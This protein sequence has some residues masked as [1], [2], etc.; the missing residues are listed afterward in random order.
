MT[1]KK[2][3]IIPSLLSKNKAEFAKHFKKVAPY[4][5][6]IQVDIMDGQFVK[7][8]NSITPD[9]IKYLTRQHKLE[10]HLMVNDVLKYIMSWIK[11][12]NVRK[13]I[14]HYEANK[15]IKKIEAINNYLKG[16]KIKTGL[17]INPNTSL[18][19]IKNII[20]LFDTI[21][22]MGVAPGK[23][24]Q[25]FQNKTIAKIKALHYKFPKL[26]IEVDGG[27]ND[28]TFKT[29]SRAGANILSPG[30]YLQTSKNIKRALNKL[31]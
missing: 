19:N 3:R 13:I 25:R 4:F 14:W 5:N 28:K 29:L 31:K 24:G 21:Q 23:Q 12:K 26:N 27:V 9:N 16:E 6:Y 30:S 10:I 22:I 8:K 20:P 11:L 1:K 17:A 15:N 7:N 18:A 2:V